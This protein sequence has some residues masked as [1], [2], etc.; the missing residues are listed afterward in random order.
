M[1]TAFLTFFLTT[2]ICF[3]RQPN[4]LFIAVDDLRPELGIYGARAITPNIDKLAAGALVFDRA[5]CNQAVCGASRTSLMTGLYPEK[6]NLRSFHVE[7]WEE[8]LSGVVTLNHHLKD[9][10]YLTIGLGKIYHDSSESVD[11]KNWD[12][13]F[14]LGGK[15][16]F[17]QESL[18]LIAKGKKLEKPLRGPASEVSPGPEDQHLDFK[19][20]AL[21][22]EILKQLHT[23]SDKGPV[24]EISDKPFF[25]AVGFTKPHLPFVAPKKYWD[26]YEPVQ[27]NMPENLTIPPGY[28]SQAANQN[29]GE[30]YHYGD[31]PRGSPKNFSDELNRRLIHGY[32]AATSFT[33]AN[34]GRVLNALEENGFG[35]NTIVVLWG[36]H[37]W[38]LGDHH[39]WCKHTNLEVDTRVPLII[40][41]PGMTTGGGKTGSLVELIDLYPTLS[42]LAGA[43]PPAHVQ[44]KSFASILKNPATIIR[45]TAYSSYPARLGK[46]NTI[47][48]SI[49]TA[50]FRYTEWWENN[51]EQKIVQ[52]VGTNLTE[53]P[54][55]TTAIADEDQLSKL[56]SILKMRVMEARR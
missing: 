19:R 20:A 50:D 42:E 22:T 28:P 37:G 36:D 46:N 4:I 52:A 17:A 54:G 44:G 33:D 45:E 14:P 43:E 3:A 23:Q 56:S 13:W 29:P 32:H 49:R 18:E 26:L 21:A 5:Y 40:R 16:Y 24:S 6:T 55:E 27:F 9:S 7:G 8:K 47:G 11:E 31:I 51:D 15:E 48:H 12:Q 2:L 25:L 53:D 38:K 1:K 35:E 10:G 34:I 30:L 39:S 41:V